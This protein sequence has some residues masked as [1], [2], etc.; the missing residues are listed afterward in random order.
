MSHG[1]ERFFFLPV[2]NIQDMQIYCIQSEASISTLNLFSGE[3]QSLSDH[4]E[5]TTSTFSG[6]FT[7]RPHFLYSPSLQNDFP[8]S[9]VPVVGRFA[10]G[11]VL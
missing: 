9:V 4:E 8:R 7:D 11:E 6:S 5:S 3:N 2:F 10:D 1:A